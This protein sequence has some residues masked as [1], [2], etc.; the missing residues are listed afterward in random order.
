MNFMKSVLL[1]QPG[2]YTVL[3]QKV[4]FKNEGQFSCKIAAGSRLGN[5]IN[6]T[7]KN[8]FFQILSAAP[9]H[10]FIHEM[11]HALADKLLMGCNSI[12]EVF[13]NDSTGCTSRV[14]SDLKSRKNSGQEAAFS[15][16]LRNIH[17][18]S[19]D[20]KKYIESLDEENK[21]EHNCLKLIESCGLLLEFI[22]EKFKTDSMCE[23]AV[24]NIPMALKFVPEKYK[25][26]A[27]CEEAV[28]CLRDAFEYVPDKLKTMEMALC[29]AKRSTT[30]INHVPKSIRT[31]EFYREVF[32]DANLDYS[33][34]FLSKEIFD[35]AKIALGNSQE[36]M[37]WKKTA[38]L[39]A[40]PIADVV[41]SSCQ[42]VAAVALK[43]RIG[44]PISIV[45]GSSGA[46]WMAGELMYAANSTIMRDIGDFG[47][48]GKIGKKYQIA[49]TV[50]L[51]SLCALGI[52][53]AT[54]FLG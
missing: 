7:L 11:G 22:P 31:H 39:L 16:Q 51:V 15:R 23:L 20:G 35:E 54:K 41:Y 9:S 45:L 50:S 21:N 10:L 30:W 29:A 1:G 14:P 37:K 4:E 32:K 27:M 46:I 3:E 40:G 49:A 19:L 17:T 43:D 36:I 38:I 24:K 42:L 8:R 5:F 33:K 18:K 47:K 34:G 52:L 44:L 2:V 53:A 12:V 48:I 13:L 28:K 25:T 26:Q 6:T